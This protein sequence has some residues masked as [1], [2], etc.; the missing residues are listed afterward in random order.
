MNSN[1]N[2]S[3]D[4]L[5]APEVCEAVSKALANNNM[6]G[7][8]LEFIGYDACLMQVQDIAELNSQYFNYMVGSEESEAGEGW[9]YDTWVDDVY[10]GKDTKTVLKAMVDGFIADNGQKED[11]IRENVKVAIAIKKLLGRIW[12]VLL[13]AKSLL[14]LRVILMI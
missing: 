7:Q 14:P 5:E 4:G 2:L 13:R 10:S 1:Q 3:N 11:H 6:A 9:D 8:K 12:Q